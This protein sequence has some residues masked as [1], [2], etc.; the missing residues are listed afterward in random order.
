[1]G[2]LTD[3]KVDE[4]SEQESLLEP[5]LSVELQRYD[6]NVTRGGRLDRVAGDPER[7]VDTLFSVEENRRKKYILVGAVSTFF[8]GAAGCAVTILYPRSSA[9]FFSTDCATDGFQ[10]VFV[11]MLGNVECNLCADWEGVSLADRFDPQACLEGYLSIPHQNVTNIVEKLNA[12]VGFALSNLT[13]SNQPWETWTTTDWNL[14]LRS[15]QSLFSEQ[16]IEWFNLAGT[17]RN[18]SIFLDPLADLFQHVSVTHLNL[19]QV[20]PSL[21]ISRTLSFLN[22]TELTSIT[23]QSAGENN[24]TLEWLADSIPNLPHLLTLVVE[25][26][27]FLNETVAERFD[28]M[29]ASSRLDELVM[30]NVTFGNWSEVFVSLPSSLSWLDLS[31]NF[32]PDADFS[33]L[34]TRVAQLSNATLFIDNAELDDSALSALSANLSDSSLYSVSLRD[35]VFG[36]TGLYEL[37]RQ[38]PNALV[39]VDVSGNTIGSTGFAVICEYGSHLLEIIVDSCSIGD[40]GLLDCSQFPLN[41]ELQVFSVQDN[42]VSSVGAQ[43]FFDRQHF[44]NGTLALDL[45]QNPLGNAVAQVLSSYMDSFRSLYL[46][47]TILTDV[48]ASVLAEAVGQAPHLKSV[49]L[50]RNN[51]GSAGCTPVVQASLSLESLYL[52]GSNCDEAS[53]NALIVTLQNSTLKYFSWDRNPLSLNAVLRFSGTLINY[54]HTELLGEYQLSTDTLADINNHTA[55]TQIESYS[56]Q[57]CILDTEDVLALCRVSYPASIIPQSMFLDENTFNSS[58]VDPYDCVI[59]A[60]PFVSSA[61]SRIQPPAVMLFIAH[62]VNGTGSIVLQ[63]SL[64]CA[65]E[66]IWCAAVLVLKHL[67]RASQHADTHLPQRTQKIIHIV[68]STPEC[69]LVMEMMGLAL[70]QY[71]GVGYALTDS[72]LGEFPMPEDLSLMDYAQQAVWMLCNTLVAYGV[73]TAINDALDSDFAGLILTPVVL[74]GASIWQQTRDT[75]EE[76]GVV[77]AASSMA[78]ATLSSL[79]G[80]SYFI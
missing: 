80:A 37:M 60:V 67:Q 49:S 42:G 18:N 51:L 68:L 64:D 57:N 59:D 43:D 69:Q 74:N 24:S 77:S 31:N 58:M 63:L 7:Q 38:A 76:E 8:L 48:G 46:D 52:S 70:R 66:L 6:G 45:S 29:L 54:T 22:A 5:R 11:P 28:E 9:L 21:D 23:L 79:P 35:N 19:T 14:I 47:Q 71:H 27:R 16:G 61:T 40:Q 10:E 73:H 3:S 34:S 26:Y 25:S 75:Y 15:L 32:V 2:R 4:H 1:M 55:V 12:L 13:L 65:P 72:V 50:S 17:G 44:N 78:Y 30:R 36:P 41:P 62:T 20:A 39:R 53:F 33:V 56:L